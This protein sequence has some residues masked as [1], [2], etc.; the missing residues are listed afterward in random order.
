[1]VKIAASYFRDPYLQETYKCNINELDF[2]VLF[3][4][5]GIHQ[6]NIKSYNL[7]GLFIDTGKR[8]VGGI[9]SHQ[10]FSRCLLQEID[11]I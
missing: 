2:Q 9:R 8:R 5:D 3:L 7:T 10:C 1:M 4:G 6:I 11:N